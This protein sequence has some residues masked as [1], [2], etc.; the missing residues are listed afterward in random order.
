MF[1]RHRAGPS[2]DSE[3][4]FRAIFEHAPVMIDAFAVDGSVVLW[5][6]ECERRLGWTAEELDAMADP[7]AVFYPDPD[8]RARVM[9][10]IERADG[11]FREFEVVAKDG[12]V[13]IQQWADF[14]LPTGSRISVGIDITEQR[15]A[16][17]NLRQAQK[18]Q[19]LGTLTGGIAHDFNNLLTIIYASA[20]LAERDFRDS[21]DMAAQSIGEI[22]RAAERG[23]DLVRRLMSFSRSE[24]L[25]RRLVPLDEVLSGFLPT[26]RRL[27]PES[28]ELDVDLGAPGAFI[29]A[30]PV[31]IEQILINLVTNARD[32]IDG[33]GRISLRTRQLHDPSG[34][35]VLLE[36]ADTGAG[37][38]TETQER[39]FEPFFTTKGP[40]RGTGLG[41]PM[42]YGLAQ[43]HEGTVTLRSTLGE[44]TTVSVRLPLRRER[45]ASGSSPPP[46]VGERGRGETILVVEDDRAVCAM[47]SRCLQRAGYV[48]LT[49]SGGDE[50]L[51]TLREHS[52]IALVLSDLVMPRM[53]GEELRER[54]RRGR[55]ARVPIAFMSGY[56]AEVSP[57]V[58]LLAKPWKPEEL[59]AFVRSCLS[60][61]DEVR[62][63]S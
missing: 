31:A 60:Q 49:A 1:M 39:V 56:S 14:E 62:A 40:G 53:G 8:T 45:R 44:G 9:A 22:V 7:L 17:A 18:M 42:V 57:D 41:L 23:A 51:T 54:M 32:A 13:R 46:A 43:Q 61:A 20:S 55:H 58:P 29:H 11:Q 12:S 21:P 33:H 25:R 50:A 52:D 47:A 19:A 24:N 34:D 35:E 48:V 36:V 15:K 16:E 27:V 10:A 2:E 37:M 6:R 4:R 28:L 63:G 59:T 3:E 38:T 5:N 30:D 26:L